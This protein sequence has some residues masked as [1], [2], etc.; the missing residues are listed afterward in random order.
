MKVMP[1]RRYKEP[2]FPT[3]AILDAHPELLRLVPKRWRANPVVLTALAAT[4]MIISGCRSVASGK[5]SPA[6]VSRVAPIFQHG[7]GRGA[8]GCQAVNPPVFLSEDE[9]R[10]VITQEAK[11]AGISFAPDINTKSVRVPT[12]DRYES[13]WARPPRPAYRQSHR[14]LLTFDGTDERR[15]VSYEYVSE[16]DFKAWE[17][18]HKGLVSLA[19]DIGTLDAAKRLQ[20]SLSRTRLTGT[21]AVFYDPLATPKE[22]EIWRGH[23]STPEWDARLKPREEQGMQLA[24]EELRKQVR[25]FIAWLKAQ[26]VI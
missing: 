8:F 23:L 2:R 24:R 1:I 6:A 22:N 9:A 10:Q 12:T 3:R 4:I 11:K 18:K 19:Y 5:G 25:D 16:S 7:E 26:G 21:Y 15:A 20:E 14:A 13:L 17:G